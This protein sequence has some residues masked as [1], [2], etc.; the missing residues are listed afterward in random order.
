MS[1]KL[2]EESDRAQPDCFFCVLGRRIS[3]S[4]RVAVCQAISTCLCLSGRSSGQELSA[5]STRDQGCCKSLHHV[6]RPNRLLLSQLWQL[7]KVSSCFRPSDSRA[8]RGYCMVMCLPG[9]PPATSAAKH[10]RQ[11]GLQSSNARSHFYL[12]I[13]DMKA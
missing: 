1:C 9:V 5:A 4:C 12:Q 8:G 7:T 3:Q 2:V 13:Q 6:A 10:Q 11:N